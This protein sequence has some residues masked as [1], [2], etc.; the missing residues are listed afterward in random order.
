M[1]QT[2]DANGFPCESGDVVQITDE[3]HHWFPALVVVDEPKVFGFQGYVWMVNN[4]RT[5]PNAQAYIRLEKKQYE[6]IG[7]AIITTGAAPEED[8]Q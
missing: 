5:E 4:S 7:R 8:K 1:N 3:G 2:H 6:R